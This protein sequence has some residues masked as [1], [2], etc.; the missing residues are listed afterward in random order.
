MTRLADLVSLV[1]APAAL[2]VPGDVLAGAASAGRPL[3]VRTAGLAAASV[4]LYW[5]GMALNDWAD[6]H[7]DAVE[8][9]ERPI[10]SGRVPPRTAFAVASGLTAAGVGIA[11][12]AGGRR[13]LRVALPLAG[14]VWAYDLVAKRTPAGPVAM[15]TARALDVMLGAGGRGAA[16]P[17]AALVGAHTLG[18]T[19]V[20]RGEVS[21]GRREVPAAALALTAGTAVGAGFTSQVRALSAPRRGGFLR[22]SR[23]ALTRAGLL[24]TY[25]TTTARP[26]V[27]AVREP[28]AG[29]MRRAVGAGILG[30]V[31][32]QGALIARAG[33]PFVGAAL[34]GALPVA[35][36]LTRKVSAT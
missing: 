7:E 14:T 28:S 12:L 23:G 36:A 32:L 4:C 1:R 25:A 17:A 20:S 26:L 29:R 16:L 22:T 15:A 6:R 9:P 31:P 5:S 11:A 13:A 2:T 34:V 18:V 30:L 27:D 19:L 21:G 10:P 24:A 33:A 3:G 35:R 8:R